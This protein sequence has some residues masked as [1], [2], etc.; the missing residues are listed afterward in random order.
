M[1][2]WVINSL[3]AEK[4]EKSKK[5]GL[6][7]L[8]PIVPIPRL[9]D[10]AICMMLDENV[11]VAKDIYNTMDIE[12]VHEFLAIKNALNYYEEEKDGIDE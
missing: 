12:E 3:L 8:L 2:M 11:K 4:S 7:E 9:H 5:L 1:Q 10:M 6:L